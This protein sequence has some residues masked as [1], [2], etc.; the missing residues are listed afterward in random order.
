MIV[1]TSALIAILLRETGAAALLD[2]IIAEGGLLPAPARVEYLRVA[3]GS[4]V[5]LGREAALL[6]D[7]FGRLGLDTIPFTADHARIAGE[8]NAQYG[9]GAGSGGALNLLD[10]M[11]YAVAKERSAPLLCTGNDFVTTDLVIHPA[12]RAG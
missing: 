11:V 10:L 1:D 8:A 9:K 2:A 12:S 4:R 7:H 3:S 6:L 5:G